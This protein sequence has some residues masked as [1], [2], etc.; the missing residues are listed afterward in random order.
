MNSLD[1]AMTWIA[2]QWDSVVTAISGIELSVTAFA[3]AFVRDVPSILILFLLVVLAGSVHLLG[4]YV[5]SLKLTDHELRKVIRNLQNNST[6][7]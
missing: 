4:R 7:F 6:D 5:K 1:N 2:A 3:D